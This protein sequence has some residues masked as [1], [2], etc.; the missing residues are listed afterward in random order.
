MTNERGYDVN[1]A[2]VAAARARSIGKRRGARVLLDRMERRF[3]LHVRPHRARDELHVEAVCLTLL[4]S[5][6]PARITEYVSKVVRGGVGDDGMLQ[7]FGMI[8]WPDIG[9][10]WVNVDRALDHD[11]LR[12][13]HQAFD[14][15]D[16]LDYRALGAR[17]DLNHDGDEVSALPATRAGCIGSVQWVAPPAGA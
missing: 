1:R 5:T 3:Q 4:G 15:L 9:G 6:Q 7:R 10:E 2:G 17:R 14:D 8:V 16:T 13:A 11:A 12:V